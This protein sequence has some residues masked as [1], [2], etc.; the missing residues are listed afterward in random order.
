MYYVVMPLD[1]YK[2]PDIFFY[3]LFRLPSLWQ[4]RKCGVMC[5]V[6]ELS[7]TEHRL[8]IIVLCLHC[9]AICGPFYLL[10]KGQTLGF[11]LSRWRP[12]K[13][14]NQGGLAMILPFLIKI[15]VGDSSC[16]DGRLILIHIKRYHNVPRV[17]I[18]IE[19]KCR[20]SKLLYKNTL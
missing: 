14:F 19:S 5:V 7:E 15:R 8:E 11:Q 6:K 18:D 2:T 10:L 3:P 9:L 16:Y 17:S 12:I 1:I 20:G 13:L 4:L